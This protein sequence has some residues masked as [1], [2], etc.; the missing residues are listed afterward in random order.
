MLKNPSI[1]TQ[2]IN[3]TIVKIIAV[4]Y[5]SVIYIILGITITY[6]LDKYI[7]KDIE[8]VLL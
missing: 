1:L 3:I 4:I 8:P 7:F 5:V 2:P 6:S